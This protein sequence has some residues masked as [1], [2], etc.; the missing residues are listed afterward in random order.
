M[1]FLTEIVFLIVS[2]LCI[3][4]NRNTGECCVKETVRTDSVGNVT[5]R[6]ISKVS[7]GACAG[8]TSNNCNYDQWGNKSSC[9]T[10]TTYSAEGEVC[11]GGADHS[12]AATPECVEDCSATQCGLGPVCGHDCG[13]CN[14]DMQC[15]EGQCEYPCYP[16]CPDRDTVTVP[17]GT[18]A[19]GCNLDYDWCNPDH[20]REQNYSVSAFAI[21][22]YE[23][24][25][26]QFSRC[27]EFGP[28]RGSSTCS[29]DDTAAGALPV[30]CARVN[31]AT[32]YCEWV[33]GALPSGPYWEVAALGGGEGPYPWGDAEPTCEM[34][35]FA[36]EE[37]GKGCGTDSARAVGENPAGANA[38]GI[39][40]MSGNASEWVTDT[41]MIDDQLF[42]IARGGSWAFGPDHLY[43]SYRYF[44]S[45]ASASGFRCKYS[46]DD[47]NSNTVTDSDTPADI[48]TDIDTDIDTDSSFDT[49]SDNDMDDCQPS[50]VSR[51]MW[52]STSNIESYLISPADPDGDG[53]DYIFLNDWDDIFALNP[54]DGSAHWSFTADGGIRKLD[55]G[56]D[57]TVYSITDNYNLY[58][59]NPDDGSVIWSLF[60][61]TQPSNMYVNAIGVDGTIYLR[62]DG[63]TLYALNPTDGSK[64]WSYNDV[65]GWDV[66]YFHTD[67]AIYLLRRDDD[68]LFSL[69]P[70]DGSVK[71][72]YT[73]T[74]NI[75]DVV[76]GTD[77][78]VY[79]LPGD[80]NNVDTV[81]A[82]SPE[83]G[84]LR[85]SY[86]DAY[87]L[88]YTND[89]DK[90]G[91]FY[92]ISGNT[93]LH[94]LDSTDGTLSW[95]F[96]AGSTI[97][98]FSFGRD[99]TVYLPSYDKN[100][101]ALN[102]ED[103]SLLWTFTA[104]DVPY[105]PAIG[106]DGTIYLITQSS[107]LYALNPENGSLLWSYDPDLYISTPNSNTPV[108]GIDGNIFLYSSGSSFSDS[109]SSPIFSLD[110]MD[111][112]K[113]WSVNLPV[114]T[115]SP[116]VTGDGILFWKSQDDA[117][118]AISTDSD[119]VDGV[120]I[121][122]NFFCVSDLEIGRCL[123]DGSWY[124]SVQTC[125]AEQNCLDGVC[126]N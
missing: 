56:K 27:R 118:W 102:P 106:D 80:N 1:K 48:G 67:G 18:Y 44:L 89:S 92:L 45:D 15:Y 126:V 49:D 98:F 91:K 101:Y 50:I 3:S 8:G 11:T 87:F 21:D 99:G 123:P 60:P 46:V 95:S 36:D 55:I 52:T 76:L 59:L 5:G 43:P 62:I 77:G 104:D 35:T 94:V 100:L 75:Q 93:V 26:E 58:A 22:R 51:V 16:N 83:D 57:R 20:T 121:P 70:T 120:C 41:E 64:K 28:C 54:I 30:Q 115:G 69:N 112:S 84:S 71:W 116:F 82:L 9:T 24:T 111:G 90:D 6:T 107:I 23:V 38:W 10:S 13:E 73:C 34:A 113:K 86:T 4:C 61:N 7:D 63:D 124:E 103:G 109:I 125:N 39:E 79:L 47:S 96:H 17:A 114:M 110:P 81:R 68:T 108:I 42:Y 53:L 40:D 122:C 12:E 32:A 88:G 66:S 72:S 105:K 25:V 29:A 85:W 14:D 37:L 78:T 117:L 65:D 19:I 2:I 119:A 31:D 74:E 33:G 97:Y